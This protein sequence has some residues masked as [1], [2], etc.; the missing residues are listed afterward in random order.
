MINEN[1]YL[2]WIEG[3]KNIHVSSNGDPRFAV[4]NQVKFLIHKRHQVYF[5]L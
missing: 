1:D 3:K 2:N 5:R 4:L